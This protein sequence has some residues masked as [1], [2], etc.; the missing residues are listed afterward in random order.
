MARKVKQCQKCNKPL[1]SDY[2]MCSRCYYAY[3]RNYEKN[4]TV[5]YQDLV[6]KHTPP[7][8]RKKLRIGD[9][10]SNEIECTKCGDVVR[11]R[12]EHDYRHCKCGES[13]IDGGSWEVRVK[14][15][16]AQARTV[17]FTFLHQEE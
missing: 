1:N 6:N 13:A 5:D 3:T 16:F 4:G 7:E 8:T 12:N 9:I 14:G 15:K 17:L 2:D 10:W 11:S